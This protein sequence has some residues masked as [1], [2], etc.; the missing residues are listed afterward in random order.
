MS[1]PRTRT[2]LLVVTGVIAWRVASEIRAHERRSPD[3]PPVPDAPETLHVSTVRD[4]THTI[5]RAV[6]STPKPHASDTHSVGQ[7]KVATTS[8]SDTPP[9]NQDTSAHVLTASWRSH[10][11]VVGACAGIVLAVWAIITPLTW[12]SPALVIAA[13]GL[14]SLSAHIAPRNEPAT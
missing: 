14:T 6:V 3:V 13:I 11:A 7:P 9:R 8:Q 5:A 1:L 2:L 10:V 4:E 12:W